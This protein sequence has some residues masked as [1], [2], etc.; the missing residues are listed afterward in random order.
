MDR[1]DHVADG[2]RIAALREKTRVL[3]EGKRVA[4]RSC[5]IALAETFGVPTRAY[6]ALRKGGLTGE[7]PCGAVLAGRLI[8]GELLGDPDPT[9][10]ITDALRAAM[11]HYDAGVARRSPGLESA[12]CGSLTDHFPVFQSD[13]RMS[14][15][16]VLAA[17]VAEVLAE[18]LARFGVSL[19]DAAI[20]SR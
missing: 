10:G 11:T 6:Q 1:E 17:D 9:G 12:T 18:T 7:G 4:H 14:T 3:Y 8:L 15:C 13:E 5:G 2:D 16:T 20:P 19:P